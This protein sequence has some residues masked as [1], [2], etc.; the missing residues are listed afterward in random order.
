MKI[1]FILASLIVLGLSI[2]LTGCE[3]GAKT[4]QELVAVKA[5]LEQAQQK[6]ADVSRARD[7]LQEQ[8]DELTK[9]RD[10]ALN[11]AKNA[12]ARLDG[13]TKQFQE[14]AKIIRELQEHVKQMQAAIE[15][16]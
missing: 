2:S 14:Q 5:A 7:M 10:E 3:G 6:L 15:K 11:E 1:S 16:L 13:L 8:V 4:E 12:R 9:S